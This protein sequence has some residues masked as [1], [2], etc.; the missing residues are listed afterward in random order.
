MEFDNLKHPPELSLFPTAVV[1]WKLIVE[2]LH[3]LQLGPCVL[4]AL[5]QT[6]LHSTISSTKLAW[7]KVLSEFLVHPSVLSP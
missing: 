6:F 3:S 2:V 1:L 5:G 7:V 4:V